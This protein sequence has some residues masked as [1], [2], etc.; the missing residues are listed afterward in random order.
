MV[1]GNGSTRL[2][3]VM[4]FKVPEPLQVCSPTAC[5]LTSSLPTV[6]SPQGR[7]PC[8]QST[9]P[10]PGS[11]CIFRKFEG[12]MPG[13]PQYQILQRLWR[14]C[15]PTQAKSMAPFLPWV[16][17]PLSRPASGTPTPASVSLSSRRAWPPLRTRSSSSLPWSPR[18]PPS[19]AGSCGCTR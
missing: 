13:H 19:T 4:C 16:R 8:C 5:M 11:L 9:L 3:S 17:C 2:L 14:G 7:R 10:F 1:T 12:S 15:P 6:H 18:P